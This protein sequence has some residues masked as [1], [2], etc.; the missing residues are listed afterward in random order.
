MQ[1]RLAFEV[2]YIYSPK[3]L[4]QCMATIKKGPVK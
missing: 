4:N 3:K 2:A 1:N